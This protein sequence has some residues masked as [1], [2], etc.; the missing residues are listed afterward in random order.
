MV[1]GNAEPKAARETL[2]VKS[3]G[4]KKRELITVR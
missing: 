4:F 1:F 3:L 2:I